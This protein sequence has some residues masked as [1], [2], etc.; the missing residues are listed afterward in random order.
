MTAFY[1]AVSLSSSE[2]RCL[3]FPVLI[4]EFFSVVAFASAFN[5]AL[6]L[7]P[8]GDAWH[9]ADCFLCTIAD[10]FNYGWWHFDQDTY[11]IVIARSCILLVASPAAVFAL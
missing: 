1:S 3:L 8:D 5:V 4:P 9:C 2:T 6:P 10:T 11:S 7:S